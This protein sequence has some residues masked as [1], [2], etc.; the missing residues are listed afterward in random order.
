MTEFG[1]FEVF[2]NIKLLEFYNNSYWYFLIPL[3]FISLILIIFKLRNRFSLLLRILVFTLLIISISV[4][5]LSSKIIIDPSSRPFLLDISSSMSM[6]AIDDCIRK[7][8]QLNVNSEHAAQKIK[9]FPFKETVLEPITFNP[10]NKTIRKDLL[11]SISTLRSDALTNFEQSLSALSKLYQFEDILLCSDAWETLGS[12]E[13]II[14]ELKR[15]KL[16]V[17]PILP[18]NR[19]LETDNLNITLLNGPLFSYMGEPVLFSGAVSNSGK[20]DFTG[21]YTFKVNS[22]NRVKKNIKIS[23]SREEKYSEYLRDL[24]AGLNKI[25]FSVNGEEERSRWIDVKEKPK[26][27][28]VHGKYNEKNLSE[29]LLK[30][31]NYEFDSVIAGKDTFPEKLEKYTGIILNNISE[32]QVPKDFQAKLKKQVEKGHGLLILGGDTSFGLGEYQGSIIEELSPLSSVPP[33]AK[34]QKLPSAV[35]LVIDK[36]GSMKIENRMNSA[37]FAALQSI[38]NLSD[39][40][41]V[42][43]VGFDHAPLVVF[44]MQKAREVKKTAEFQ[45]TKLTS[46]GGTNLLPGLQRARYRLSEVSAGKKHIIVLTDGIFPHTSNQFASEM[47]TIR[48]EGITMSTIALGLDADVPFLKLLAKQTG[49]QFYQVLNPKSLPRIFLDDIKVVIGEDTLKEQSEFPIFQGRSGLTS[50]TVS[51]IPFLRGFVE[52]KVKDGAQLELI[53]KKDNEEFPIFANWTFGSGKVYAFSSD[54]SGRWSSSWLRWPMIGN[55][56]DDIFKKLKSLEDITSEDVKFDI[57]YHMQGKRLHVQL[58][59]Y[60]QEQGRAK[61]AKAELEKKDTGTKKNF[62]IERKD[63]GR[64]EGVI[65]M[66]EAG[67]FFLKIDLD[68]KPLPNVGIS[69]SSSELGEQKGNGVNTSFLNNLA[70]QTSGNVNPKIEELKKEEI[71]EI[72]QAKVYI[73]PFVLLALILLVIEVFIREKRRKR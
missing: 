58:F 4:P 32:K 22:Q 70:R 55:F 34:V 38:R 30:T 54:L 25:T 39:E 42:M 47:N 17:H 46:D 3:I 59:V 13:R 63:S 19:L 65:D 44:D 29:N 10:E 21:E 48:R 71:Q 61:L 24:P 72:P 11:K 14:P 7:V 50:S 68:S 9:L 49:G 56:W 64:F 37:R 31:L 66:E 60:E 62:I 16:K 36:S 2:R 67:D 45:L 15:K 6:Q 1:F 20:S 12:V 27:L 33:R 5:F 51:N 35:A 53:T 69:I 57:R 28:V 40:D 73:T 18:D 26:L 41:Y 52:T 43:V 23:K 8:I